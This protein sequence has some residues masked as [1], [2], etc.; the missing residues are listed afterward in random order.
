MAKRAFR[1]G[2]ALFL[3][4][5]VG[6]MRAQDTTR[7]L[8]SAADKACAQWVDSVFAR[9][10]LQE[11]IGQL[12]VPRVPAVDS[13]ETR[14]QVKEWVKKYKIGGLLF[15]QGTAEEEA[16]VTNYAQK[17]ARV[18]LMI[19]FDGE[20]GL[21]MRL[22]GVP[23]YPRNA[24]LGCITDNSLIEAYGREV[25]RQLRE[26]GVQVN[27][28]PVADVNTNPLNPV[29]NV[30]SFGENPRLVAEKVVAYGKGLESGG[31][32]SVSKHF[33]GHG[34]TDSD[35]HKVLP[36]VWGD[37]LRLDS[38]ELYPFKA[39]VK[40]GLG[41]V[42]IAHLQV[43]AIEPDEELPS[44]LSSN[45]VNGL[46]K[47][48]LGFEGLVFT[49]ALDMKGVTGAS[50]YYAAA[51]LAGNDM[52]LVQYTPDKAL[53]ELVKAVHA[54]QISETLINEKCRKVLAYK[55]M[56]GLRERKPKVQVSGLGYRINSEEAH[57]LAS[58][59]RKASVTVLNNYFNVLPLAGGNAQVAVLSL[60]ADKQD[61]AFVEA[62]RQQADVDVYRLPWNAGEPEKG[63]VRKALSAYKRVV[64]S[65]AGVS[66]VSEDDVAFLAGLNL[67]APLVYACF[68]PYRLL[69][70]LTPA[71]SKASAVVLAHSAEEDLQQHVAR[72][73]FGQEG[74]N[75][76]LSMS[77]GS[78]FPAG[79]GCDL[80]PGKTKGAVVPDD[81]GMKSYILQRIDEVASKGI[82]A[83]AYPGCRILVL[84]DGIPVY[85]KGF[86][87]HSPTDS[88]TVRPTDLFDLASLTKT[89]ATLLAVMKLYD[90][91]KLRLDDK[92]SK[93]LS[94]LRGTNKRNITIR[95][96]LFHES[97]LPP[98]I[99]F[100][101]DVIDPRSVHGPYAQ[102]EKDEWHR[103]QIS[104]HSYYSSDFKFK[105]G[106]VSSKP[107]EVYTLH[108]ADG[109]W[110][111]KR[112]KAQVLRGI[113]SCKLGENRY[114][115]SDLGFILLQQVVEQITQLP[116]DLY[117]DKEFYAPMGL[118]RT[119]FLPLNRYPKAEIMPTAFND[120]LRRQDICGYVHDETAACLGGIAGH[121]GLFSTAAE[122]AR[123][124]QMLLNGGEL[125][126]KRY[127]SAE[128]CH[129]FTIGKSLLS[130]R[131]L[132][133]D[134]P[135]VGIVKRSP[136]APSAPAEVFG[137]TGFTGTCVW[138]DPVSKTVYVFLSNRLCPNVWNTK[139]GDMDI[140]TDIQEL[141]FES[142]KTGE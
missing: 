45:V 116:M 113:A 28:A 4:A 5:S 32:L 97:G 107:S 95:E 76:R 126:G 92:V 99:R 91:G 67:S 77:I 75:G 142:L 104:E 139:L 117:L 18:P 53:D 52:L 33:P 50:Q 133:F 47:D 68:T 72:L 58:K 59:L 79:T 3:L 63:N 12:L 9:L 26:L 24:A 19:T 20:W 30:R 57:M 81:Y 8:P 100:Y 82:E 90:E 14:K 96:L 17:Y 129:L 69:N 121:A 13:K 111:N 110:M 1:W 80:V 118:Q 39:M 119:L 37:R 44:S 22:Q 31:V 141:I 108:M 71:L 125:D 10:S 61:S 15:A 135:D 102:R 101:V 78:L 85:D 140:R 131:G 124:Y 11:K 66:Y 34:D 65:I 43:P 134:R 106:M 2:A 103:T 46:L 73:L 87:M 83:G 7:Y 84:K 112:F 88:T 128:T 138:A 25:A 60:G 122:V 54:G 109:M 70:L 136:C 38:M 23:E 115:Y 137:H 114:V 86:G 42:M 127:L 55:Y 105:R 6:V 40:A 62:M 74:A 27:F 93:F 64:V 41:G 36:R 49:D 29:I 51:V 94:F 16:I 35:S 89:T 123:I 130:R 48:E 132:G 98:Y 56:L 120:F 21:A